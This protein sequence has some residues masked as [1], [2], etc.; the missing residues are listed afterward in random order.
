MK[1]DHDNAVALHADL[2]DQYRALEPI[3]ALKVAQEISGA[4]DDWDTDDT[5]VELFNSLRALA[6]SVPFIESEFSGVVVRGEQEDT[7]DV[8]FVDE[9]Q[10][11]VDVRQGVCESEVQDM[12]LV[13]GVRYAMFA[14]VTTVSAAGTA[15]H[16]V[17]DRSASE[18]FSDEEAFDVVLQALDTDADMRRLR[19]LG[20]VKSM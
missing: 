1:L 15:Y 19:L 5:L 2:Y 20:M 8:F 10:L 11:F 4:G 14:S 3:D 17:R 13:M 9:D 7:F 18:A 12:F 16:V 6:Q